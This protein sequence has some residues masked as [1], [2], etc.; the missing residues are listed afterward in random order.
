MKRCVI[1]LGM[2]RS[3]TS[4][5]TGVLKALGV[6]IGLNLAVPGPTNPKGYFEVIDIARLNDDILN[7]LHSSWDSLFALPDNWWKGEDLDGYKEKI[8]QIVKTSFEN[9]DIIGIKDPRL[10][11]L[12]PLWVET[13]KGLG[14]E[15]R[16][17]IPL[18]NPLEIAYSLKARDRFSLG[19]SL[20]LWMIYML[21]AEFYTRECHRIFITFD[22]LLEDASKTIGSVS[23]ALKIKFPRSYQEAEKEIA[24]FL[25]INLKHHNETASLERVL[26][27]EIFIFYK[28]LSNIAAK[29]TTSQGDVL[30]ID[31][32]RGRLF[33]PYNKIFFNKDVLEIITDA[34]EKAGVIAEKD[35]VIAE[36]DA[37]IA[38]KDARIHELEVKKAEL[39]SVLSS[40]S[41]RLTYPLRWL[42]AR[43]KG[44]K[45]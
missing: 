23:S 11:R 39:E 14:M 33:D 28:L 25:D 30:E 26:S 2:H 37:A 44:I 22:D 12:L 16:Y 18:R 17:V 40:K 24:H 7:H 5:L 27:D 6:D 4:A 32:I 35:G 13:L 34:E 29:E 1:V 38:D 15:T 36:K 9:T 10:C 21:E 20:L 42:S 41:W 19:K 43:L 45:A 3:G 31:N 8:A